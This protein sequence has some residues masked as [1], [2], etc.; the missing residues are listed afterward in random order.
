MTENIWDLM[1]EEIFLED[2]FDILWRRRERNVFEFSGRYRLLSRK[3]V[4]TSDPLRS[5]PGKSVG[6]SKEN[7]NR[8]K[9]EVG[10]E[11]S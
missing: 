1:G 2:S 4:R 7:K 9:T 8:G 3:V 11:T 10:K 5:V 6:P